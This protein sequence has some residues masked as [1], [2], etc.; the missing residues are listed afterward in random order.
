ML[1]NSLVP[2]LPCAWVAGWLRLAN[3]DQYQSYLWNS[4]PHNAS[5]AL[6]GCLLAVLGLLC[7]GTALA[8]ATRDRLTHM[9]D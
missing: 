5:T 3:R 6:D 2:Y 7:F 8:A 9:P 1:I 4:A